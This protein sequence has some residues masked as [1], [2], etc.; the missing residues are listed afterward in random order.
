MVQPDDAVVAQQHQR[1]VGVR[2]AEA[3][4]TI[5]G[6]DE[7]IEWWQS[8]GRDPREKLLILS[9]GMDIDSIE[10][11]FWHFKDRVR[12]SYGWGTNLTNDFRGC[13]PNGGNALDPISLVC[14]VVEAAGRPAVKLSDNPT[15]ATGP[16]A[17]LRRYLRIF[18]T[19][20]MSDHSVTV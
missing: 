18:G 9:D 12:V 2:T 4:Q 6:G 16:D 5:E 1:I 13:A 19:E 7:L 20:G 15:K 10:H 11:S 3:A 8:K 17:D 14:K